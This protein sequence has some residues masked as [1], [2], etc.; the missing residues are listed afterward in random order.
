MH[1]VIGSD[2][3]E[4]Y[5]CFLEYVKCSPSS[6]YHNIRY[7]MVSTF[8]RGHSICGKKT[9]NNMPNQRNVGIT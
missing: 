8:D 2:I 6:Y 1:D 3:P 7:K 5:N 9:V 4:K